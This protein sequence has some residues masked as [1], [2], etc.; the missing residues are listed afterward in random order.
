MNVMKVWWVIGL[1]VWLWWGQPVTAQPG[2]AKA[3]DGA[4]VQEALLHDSRSDLYRS[5]LGAQ[6]AGQA[7]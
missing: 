6:P 1:G 2:P 3:D 7:V 5:P 4:I